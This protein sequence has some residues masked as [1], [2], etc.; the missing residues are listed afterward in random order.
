M[1]SLS[2]RGFVSACVAVGA[3][4]GLGGVTYALGS[5]DELLRP[6]GAQDESEL[7]SLCLRCDRC[8]SACPTGVIGVAHVEDGLLAA[9]TPLLDYHKGICDFCGICADVCATGAIGAFDETQEK[10]GMA[11]VQEDRCVAY[12]G[13]CVVCESACPYEAITVNS[14]GHPVVN[15]DLCNGCGAC[16]NAC[17]ALV[18]R[19]FSGGTRRGIEVVSLAAYERIGSTSVADGSGVSVR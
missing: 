8:R 5:S 2:R 11:I 7:L 12:F 14:S 9:R 1:P 4:F 17:P 16:V 6:P 18:Y 19:S 13:G 10:I 15:P 3:S